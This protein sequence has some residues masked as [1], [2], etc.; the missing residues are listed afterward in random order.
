MSVTGEGRRSKFI[1]ERS[2]TWLVKETAILTDENEADEK[3][4]MAEL[5]F[6][7]GYECCK[8]GKP[9]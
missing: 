8:R 6:G 5:K 1:K 2:C 7:Q 9:K 4:R 3:E